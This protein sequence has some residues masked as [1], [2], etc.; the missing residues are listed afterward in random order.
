L[1]G[2][3]RANCSARQNREPPTE[4]PRCKLL[5]RRRRERGK[6]FIYVRFGRQVRPL[7]PTSRILESAAMMRTPIHLFDSCG[8]G[9]GGRTLGAKCCVRRW[10]LRIRASR[11]R[12]PTAKIRARSKEC[13]STA[14]RPRNEHS[15]PVAGSIIPSP[16]RRPV[17]VSV[18]TDGGISTHQW[19]DDSRA[20]AVL[21]FRRESPL[22][23]DLNILTVTAS[24]CLS[25]A[26]GG[27]RAVRSFLYG[28][29][30]LQ[31]R[32]SHRSSCCG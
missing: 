16:H 26:Q 18:P 3:A 6:A 21:F 22:T 17:T 19:L 1:S 14:V 27:E 28:T 24:W 30:R 10:Q 4:C 2:V 7:Q 8:C 20:T 31:R 9:S 32:C 5:V 11:Q 12:R 25:V 23:P 29:S 15:E 13:F